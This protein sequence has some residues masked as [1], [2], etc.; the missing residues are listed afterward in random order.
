MLH[1]GLCRFWVC[2]RGAIPW[3]AA[4]ATV[5]CGSSAIGTGD[6]GTDAGQQISL[7]GTDATFSF[8]WIVNGQ[9]PTD[10]TVDPCT[11]ANIQYIQM[12]VVDA[13]NPGVQE[14]SFQF[15]CRLGHYQS[16]QR[17]LRAGSYRIY[18]QA[19]S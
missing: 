9:D 16:A 6:G 11:P 15:D 8:S 10:R 2:A 13:N 7:H 1:V 18:W 5:S 19:I 17:E 3:L 12:V 4:I 14:V